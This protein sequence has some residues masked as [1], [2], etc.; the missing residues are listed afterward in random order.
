MDARSVGLVACAALILAA[1]ALNTSETGVT[2]D[3]DERAQALATAL[4]PG[5]VP[6]ARPVLE[7][8]K[9]QETVFFRLQTVTGMVL[10]G[11]VLVIAGRRSRR[12]ASH[13]SAARR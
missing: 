3:A 5:Y 9:T 13:A 6:W 11:V 8:D 10:F 12:G 7:P 4:A 1:I 2:G